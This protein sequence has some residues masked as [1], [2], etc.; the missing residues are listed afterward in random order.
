V[1][2]Q[3]RRGLLTGRFGVSGFIRDYETIGAETLAPPVKQNNFAAFAL[4][5]FNFERTVLQLGGRVETN[6]YQP[7]SLP[8]RTFQDRTFTGISASA[9]VRFHIFDNASLVANYTHSY[10]APALEELYNLGPHIG[11][12]TFEIGN[13]DLRREIGNGLDASF[14]YGTGRA[15]FEANAFYYDFSNFVFLA[16]TGAVEDG[17]PEA[18]YSQADSSFY[19]SEV[20]LNFGLI[21]NRLNLDSSFDI[22]RARIKDGPSLPRIPPVRGRFGLEFLAGGLRI[23]P[24]AV[25]ASD[26]DRLFLT[27]TRTAGYT[28]FNLRGSY[29]LPQQHF[30]HVFTFNAF[31][32]G[33]RLYRNHLSFIKEFAPEVGRGVRVA[34]TLRF[35]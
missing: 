33:D 23:Q 25:F 30:A 24:E 12:L 15:Q 28:T 21:P 2:E 16:P 19:G 32:L 17:L 11:T 34:Y 8:D 29:T 27:E 35:F 1:L 14:R 9:G 10:R 26:Q 5:E 6:R 31:N 13:S 22:V 3:E 4:E 20:G 7:G 18:V